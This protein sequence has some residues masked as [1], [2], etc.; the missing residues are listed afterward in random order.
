VA[1]LSQEPEVDTCPESYPDR[2][3]DT[4]PDTIDRCPKLAGPVENGGCPIERPPRLELNQQIVFA[5]GN[6]TVGTDQN[7][8]LDAVAE[9]LKKHAA[10]RVQI[11]GH[12]LP[13]GV[14]SRTPGLA[15]QRADAVLT[16]LVTKGIARTR[17][18]AKGLAATPGD[19]PRVEFVILS[20]GI[21]P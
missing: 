18:Q 7:Q 11:E 12:Q 3:G 20:D 14:E 9:A 2:D 15:Q 4:V 13:T 19:T 6:A 10:P 16:Y 8:A 17:L 5:P 21:N 1:T